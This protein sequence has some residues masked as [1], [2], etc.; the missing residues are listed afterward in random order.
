MIPVERPQVKYPAPT[1]ALPRQD[2]TR[3]AL[4]IQ[5]SELCAVF[6][7]TDP[8]VATRLL[9]QLLGVLQPDTSEPVDPVLINQALALVHDVGPAD[10]MEAMLA[11]MLVS[12]EY[13]AMDIMRRATH[14]AQT[15]AGRQSY[16]TLSLKAMRTFA[17]LLE[18]LN[19]GRGKGVTQRV[20]VER[21]TVEAGGQA[22]VGAVDA[23]QGGGG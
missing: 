23:R 1:A 11:I 14:P 21:V 20:I 12:A 15:A 3:V 18:A 22:V 13:A 19:H 9:S 8:D 10:A 2:G 16:V 7:V 4:A 6:G 17:Q 5:P